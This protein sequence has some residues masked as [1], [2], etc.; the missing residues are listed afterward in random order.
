MRHIATPFS[1]RASP[2]LPAAAA[3]GKTLDRRQPFGMTEFG[4]AHMILTGRDD[5][6]AAFSRS[7]TRSARNLL[8][9]ELAPAG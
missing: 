8:G 9:D 2:S 7:F 5:S 4:I 3:K 1:S 6:P